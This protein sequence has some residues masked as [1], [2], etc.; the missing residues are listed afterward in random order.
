[1]SAEEQNS[2]QAIVFLHGIL[3]ADVIRKAWPRFR[4]FRGIR[5]TLKAPGASIHFPIAPSASSIA[6]RANVLQV[7]IDQIQADSVHLIAHSMGGLDA[8]YLINN[9]DPARRI[10]SLTTVGTP[11]HGSELVH[12][13]ETTRGP[14][15]SFARHFLYPGILELTPQ[16]CDRFNRETPDRPDVSYRSWAG[17]RPEEEMPLMYRTQTRVLQREVGEN[18]SQVGV[19]SA[20]WG[21]FRGVVRADHLELAGWSLGLPKRNIQRPFDHAGFYQL[22]VNEAL[23]PAAEYTIEENQ[24]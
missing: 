14:V 20:T 13:V 1:V 2:K 12:W 5:E 10:R 11:H 4:Y 16:A 18:D 6:N 9:C 19:T 3:G 23:C 24:S 22:L 7:F 21:V 17:Y 8:R 15:Q